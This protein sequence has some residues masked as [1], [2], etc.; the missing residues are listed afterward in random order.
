MLKT[1]IVHA[2]GLFF[3]VSCGPNPPSGKASD[4][5]ARR[6]TVILDIEGGR[7]MNPRLWNPFLPGCRLDNGFRQ[8]VIEPL[9]MLNFQSGEVEPWL[10]LSMSPNKAMTEWTLRLRPGIRWSDG[11]PFTSEDVVYTVDLLLANAPVLSWSALMRD[12]VVRAAALD[13]LTVRFDLRKPDPRFQI[14]FWAVRIAASCPIVPAHIF[15]G[16]DPMNFKN[17]DPAK[18]WPVF[19]GAY[20]VK[21]VSQTE[22]LYERDDGWWGAKSGFMPLPRPR[23]LKWTWYG[24]EETRTA[25]MAAGQ[26]DAL[27]DISLGAFLALKRMN[28]RV[29]AWFDKFPWATIDPCARNLEFNCARPPW[30]DRDL[31]WAVNHALDRNLIISVAYEGTSLPSSTVFPLYPPMMKYVEAARSEA[32]ARACPI[33]S[34]DPGRAKKIIESK[35]YRLNEDGYYEKDGVELAMA[36]TAPENSIEIVR[37]AQ[38]VVEQLQNVGINATS[39]VEGSGSYFENNAFGRTEA[40]I[41][42][43]ACNSVNEP[44]SSLNLFN[45]RFAVPIGERASANNWRWKNEAY[46]R[47]VDSMGVLPFDDPRVDSLYAAAIA[48]W[49]DD[50]PIIPLTQAKKLIP[51][52]TA[53]WTGWPTAS[54]SYFQPFTWWNS[55]HRIIHHLEPAVP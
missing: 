21:T 46:S 20:R 12:R 4:S 24:P 49:M 43:S 9:F 22:F 15:R 3:L 38:V 45:S 51:F 41:G 50:L 5:G 16:Q 14:D 23:F 55:T 33:V 34:Y 18:G 30:N 1:I 36:L 19:T 25:A 10:G 52:S 17:Y 40:C 37:I 2:L 47:L 31:R 53:F 13:S 44:Y 8:A 35:G 39:R 29:I 32:V 6:E 7:V 54:D 48:L 11:V 42:W 27:N 26:L 28:P